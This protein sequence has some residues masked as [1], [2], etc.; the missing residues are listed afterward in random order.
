MASMAKRRFMIT[1]VAVAVLLGGLGV[2]VWA[3]QRSLYYQPDRT[4]P[5]P[6]S[7]HLAGGQDVRLHTEDGLTLRAWV[8]RPRVS[9]NA[10]VLYL[11]GNAGNRAGRASVGQALAE[12]GFTVLLLDYRGYGGNPGSPT[13]DGLLLDARAGAGWLREHGFTLGRTLYVGE[14]LGTGVAVKLAAESAPAGVLLRS[15]YTSFA[16]VIA[17]QLGM[18]VGRLVRDRWDTLATIEDVGCPVL[19]L[20]G[21]VDTLIPPEQSR[22]VADAAPLLLDYVESPGAGHN[23]GL[24]FG[25]ELARQARRLANATVR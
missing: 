18:P 1:G 2:A 17:G 13:E 19:V 7:G 12:Q 4:D 24:W 8:V 11:P 6:A 14:S 23:D 5:A 15:P 20:A 21:S 3:G 9:R 25:S 22:A 16:D 10:A